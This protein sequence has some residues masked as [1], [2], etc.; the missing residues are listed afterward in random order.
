MVTPVEPQIAL[1]LKQQ[2]VYMKTEGPGHRAKEFENLATRLMM[3]QIR[4]KEW[5][6]LQVFSFLG[7][8]DAGQVDEQGAVYIYYFDR[9]G[10]KDWFIMVSADG[11]R[12]NTIGVNAATELGEAKLNPYKDWSDVRIS[13]VKQQ[14]HQSR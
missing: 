11:N 10:S 14:I 3:N 13:P 4:H 5:S 12:V 6:L 1:L 9:F 2:Q 8:P 7:M